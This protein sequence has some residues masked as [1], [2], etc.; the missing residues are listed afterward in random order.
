[1]S[2]L[3]FQK[4]WA[5]VPVSIIGDIWAL[6]EEVKIEVWWPSKVL[7]TMRIITFAP[8]VLLIDIWTKTCLVG[9]NHKFFQTH[10]LFKLV[11]ITGEFPVGHEVPDRS[12]LFGAEWQRIDFLLLFVQRLYAVHK[13]ACHKG[14]QF[15]WG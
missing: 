4:V 8:L 10:R 14:V 6:L 7:L 9:I 11:Q 12:T 13:V 2:I 15:I 5:L 3:A 1:M